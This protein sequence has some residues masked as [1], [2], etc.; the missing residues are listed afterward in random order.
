MD[1]AE[2]LKASQQLQTWTLTAFL[3]FMQESMQASTADLVS[4][5]IADSAQLEALVKQA[6]GKG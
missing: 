4:A 3:T 5:A 1:L 2:K 6:T